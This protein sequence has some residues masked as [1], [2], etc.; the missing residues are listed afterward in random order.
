[1]ELKELVEPEPSTRASRETGD[2]TDT[3]APGT[4]GTGGTGAERAERAER[5]TEGREGSGKG[6]GWF[7]MVWAEKCCRF[8]IVLRGRH[9]WMMEDLFGP[10]G[11]WN[12]IVRCRPCECAIGKLT[13]E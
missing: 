7:D 8:C 2:T 13:A 1:M 11:M 4:G 6:M 12:D 9:F 5:A 3:R 10:C